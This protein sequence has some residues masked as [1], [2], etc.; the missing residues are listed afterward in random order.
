MAMTAESIAALLTGG[1]LPST[2]TL[3]PY[4]RDLDQALVSLP[5]PSA[6]FVAFQQFPVNTIACDASNHSDLSRRDA[7]TEH[8][9]I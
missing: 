9:Q 4:L 5:T 2:Q 3:P 7:K 8:F 6:I 1:T